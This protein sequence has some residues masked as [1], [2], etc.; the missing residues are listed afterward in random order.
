[1]LEGV[2]M[3]G[4]TF[5]AVSR[6]FGQGSTR[7]TILGGLAGAVA[8]V[9]GRGVGPEVAPREAAA[10]ICRPLGG[11]CV[12]GRGLECCHGECRGNRCR[13]PRGQRRCKG[14]CIRRGRCC[15][16]TCRRRRCPAGKKRCQGRCVRRQ[17]CCGGCGPR[18]T[19]VNG[20]C[21]DLPG[22][23]NG[24]PCRVFA[25]SQQYQ[26]D[27][28]GLA[29]A[30][31]TCQALANASSLTAGG[32]Y[33]AWLS[34]ELDYPANRFTNIDQT[35]PYLLTNGVKI[36][37]D[38]ATLT[39]G[40]LDARIDI[41]ETGNAVGEN[42]SAVLVWTKTETNGQFWS[43][44]TTCGDWTLTDNVSAGGDSRTN[45]AFWSEGFL[46]L[47]CSSEFRLYCFEQG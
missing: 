6:R 20:N 14:R 4:S 46:N 28:G 41:D 33:K 34:T 21:V 15:G 22:C 29:G 43:T 18:Q 9:L 3:Q 24:G 37:D 40:S 45:N 32:T 17:V 5:D 30:D 26:A 12:A 19:C 42:G 39:D 35:G 36:A 44:A 16:A 25:T 47:P 31:A 2:S 23:G 8:A 10:A 38:W 27:L 7:R 13:C 11:A 1:M